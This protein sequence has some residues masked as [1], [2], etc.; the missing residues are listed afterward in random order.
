MKRYLFILIILAFAFSAYSKKPEQ[1]KKIQVSV[2]TTI[3]TD[4]VNAQKDDPYLFFSIDSV[5]CDSEGNI[6]ILDRKEGCVKVLDRH[7]RFL[8]RMLSKGRGPDEIEAPYRIIINRFT[9][10]L[11]VLNLNGYEIKEFDKMGKFVN[12]YIPPDQI[13]L[14]F[15]FLDEERII[16]VNTKSGGRFKILNLTTRKF[17]KSFASSSGAPSIVYGNQRFVLEGGILWTCHDDK[18]ELI[19]YDLNTEKEVVRITLPEVYREYTIDKGTGAGGRWWSARIRQFAQPLLINGGLYVLFSRWE[20][21]SD[22]PARQKSLDLSLYQ[23]DGKKIKKIRDLPE[24]RF[25]YLGTSWQNR[26]LLYGSDPYPHLKIL[27]ISD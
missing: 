4:G 21:T 8:R 24:A 20:W 18:T 16:F 6:Y 17:E 7:G 1:E 25:M 12:L 5:A 15:D 14:F 2:V 11:F 27:E 23:L 10:R 19:G 3:G 26:I 9:G 22:K 13:M